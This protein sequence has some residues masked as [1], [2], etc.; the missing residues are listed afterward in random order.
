MITGGLPY[1]VVG[2]HVILPVISRYFTNMTRGR[3]KKVFML[4]LMLVGNSP[5]I[6][7]KMKTGFSGGETEKKL[8]EFQVLS[9][10]K[11]VF[12]LYLGCFQ[13]L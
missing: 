3:R 2:G 1:L 7:C 11:W 9:G 5:E 10:K 4:I 13:E 6:G 8:K 12:G